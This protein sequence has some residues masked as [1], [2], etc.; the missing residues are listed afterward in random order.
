VLDGD[1]KLVKRAWEKTARLYR[2]GDDLGEDQNLANAHS[3]KVAE[4]TA[5]HEAWRKRYYPNPVPP[6]AKRTTGNFPITP[7]DP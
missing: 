7:Q 4:L 1:W 6:V 2:P 3:A 5:K